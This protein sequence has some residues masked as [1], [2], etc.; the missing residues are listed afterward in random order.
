[1]PLAISAARGSGPSLRYGAPGKRT[2][3]IC[4][5]AGSRSFWP[6]TGLNCGAG[7]PDARS[8]PYFPGRRHRRWLRAC[9]RAKL[10]DVEFRAS[11]AAQAVTEAAAR[12]RRVPVQSR[13]HVRLPAT[14]TDPV[15]RSLTRR[16]RRSAA[17]A[18]VNRRRRIMGWAW[19]R[20]RSTRSCTDQRVVLAAPTRPR[21]EHRTPAAG[22]R[23][24]CKLLFAMLYS[25]APRAPHLAQP[26]S[27]V[28]TS[29]NARRSCSAVPAPKGTAGRGQRRRRGSSSIQSRAH[30]QPRHVAPNAESPPHRLRVTAGQWSRF[31]PARSCPRD[32][33]V[34]GQPSSATCSRAGRQAGFKKP[35]SPI[36]GRGYTAAQRSLPARP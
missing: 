29:T 23:E 7:Q 6:A 21:V 2:V 18:L 3:C 17:V 27:R 5:A 20:A 26:P 9:H 35:N 24:T 19:R 16:S 12:R 33:R 1:M 13:E 30:R 10:T 28:L 4:T 31:R 34:I 25:R 22:R 8:L 11:V 14:H 15:L 32:D 36:P